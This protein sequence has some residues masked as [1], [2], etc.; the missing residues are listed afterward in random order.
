MPEEEDALTEL[1]FDVD[2]EGVVRLPEALRHCW[3]YVHGS[4]L[5]RLMTKAYELALTGQAVV[6]GEL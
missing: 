6:E 3:Y 5:E 2:D 1:S 4:D